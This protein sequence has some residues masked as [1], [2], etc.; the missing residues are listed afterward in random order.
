MNNVVIAY[1]IEFFKRFGLKTPS[2]FQVL[3]TLGIIAAILTGLPAFVEW[4]N[5]DFGVGVTLPDFWLA[6][7]DKVI[8]WC[9]FVMWVVAKLPISDN[10]MPAAKAED[11]LPFTENKKR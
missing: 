11:K 2:F 1:I 8:A 9:G 6:I 5:A 10:A 4:L 3:Q 7:Q